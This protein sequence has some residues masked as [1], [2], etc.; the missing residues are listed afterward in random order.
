MKRIK[1]TLVLKT[2]ND[3]INWQNK[4]MVTAACIMIALPNDIKLRQETTAML[5]GG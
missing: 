3:A 1:L 4:R 2:R 5:K